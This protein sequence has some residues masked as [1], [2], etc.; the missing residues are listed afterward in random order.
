M[1]LDVCRCARSSLAT[2]PCFRLVL[3]WKSS[4]IEQIQDRHMSDCK[5]LLNDLP[6]LN[7]VYLAGEWPYLPSDFEFDAF[8]SVYNLSL[9]HWSFQHDGP[10][11]IQHR[12]DCSTLKH[13]YL[14]F[15]GY[16]SFVSDFLIRTT[17][18]KPDPRTLLFTGD[19]PFLQVD[20]GNR[21]HIDKLFAVLLS[22]NTQLK[23]LSV[24][25]PHQFNSSKRSF[26]DLDAFLAV[27]K[28]RVF[29][30]GNFSPIYLFGL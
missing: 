6:R 1:I 10:K 21:T 17:L 19:S 12:L 2:P 20:P 16:V 8:P 23:S 3:T 30:S 9:K 26:P 25:S 7:S 27:Q 5:N 29:R 22:H 24:R 28:V 18:L 13:L 15:G 11:A 4:E 14:G